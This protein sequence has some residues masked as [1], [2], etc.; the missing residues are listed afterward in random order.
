MEQSNTCP[1]SMGY[2]PPFIYV[3]ELRG[4]AA[5][6]ATA[7]AAVPLAP[8]VAASSLPGG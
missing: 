1:R 3:K 5:A 7:T 4:A 2:Y 6:T 8:L